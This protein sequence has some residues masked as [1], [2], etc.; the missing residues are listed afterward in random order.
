V[1]YAGKVGEDRYNYIVGVT[2]SD[3]G[4]TWRD[5]KFVIDPDGDGPL[6]ASDPCPWIGPDG[7][8]WL[9]WCQNGGGAIRALFTMTTGNPGDENPTWSTPRLI[10]DGVVMCKPTFS[11]R[12]YAFYAVPKELLGKRF[13]FSSIDR[14]SAICREAG[15]VYVLTPARRRNRDSAV[16]ALTKQAFA[17]VA[18]REGILFLSANGGISSG[19][20]C[21][22]YQKRVEAG[23]RI[24]FGK[25]GVV[26]F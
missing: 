26:V 13:V 7:K 17:K 6:R 1:W 14:S 19:N 5:L 3:D 4:K 21:T 15:M 22:V 9:F 20:V 24:E 10:D 25:W 16:D 11:D 12:K 2:S 8:L 23:E 18:L